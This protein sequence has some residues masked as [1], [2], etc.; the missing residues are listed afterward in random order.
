MQ[1]TNVTMNDYFISMKKET[2]F[3]LLSKTACKSSSNLSNSLY[4]K[5]LNCFIFP[6]KT[7][8]AL[9]KLFFI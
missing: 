9:F 6:K 5:K 2:K 8:N 7:I 3:S 1:R 4:K